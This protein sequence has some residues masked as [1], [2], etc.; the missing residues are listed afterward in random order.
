MDGRYSYGY[1]ALNATYTEK[2][3]GQIEFSFFDPN[4]EP[5]ILN[6]INNIILNLANI[7]DCLKQKL[8]ERG[9]DP[10]IIENEIN[11]SIYLQV[12]IDLSNQ[13]KHGYPLIK[14]RRSKKD[15]LI[16]N[17]GRSLTVSNKPDNI[18]FEK[19]DGS[20]I[21]NMMI[22]IDA[23][24]VDSANNLLCRIGDLVENALNAWNTIIQKYN[25]K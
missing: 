13:E 14:N 4:D 12:I 3:N 9:D 25:I 20:A 24:I 22:S 16:K 7:K 1:E 21:Q 19:N 8:T 15:P 11:N 6:Q 23:D 5:K 2:I 18:R 10:Q 17:I